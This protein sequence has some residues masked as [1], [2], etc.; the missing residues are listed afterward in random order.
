MPQKRVLIVG[1][2][3]TGQQLAWEL[4][5]NRSQPYRAVCFVDDDASLQGQARARHAGG[6][7]TFDIPAPSRSTAS[8]WWRSRCRGDDAELQEILALCEASQVPV[9]MVPSLADVVAGRAQRG[10][11]RELTME[12]L[13]AREPLDVDEDACRAAIS[14]AGWC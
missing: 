1:A 8:I 11:L 3:D 13:L 14:R 2:G 9:R 4:Q 12:D 6:G 10:E 7:R 5:H